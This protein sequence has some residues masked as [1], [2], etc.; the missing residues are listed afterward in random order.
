MGE[1]GWWWFVR[2]LMLLQLVN[3]VLSWG[4]DGHFA[5][6]KIAEVRDFTC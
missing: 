4:K 2:A 5:T 3:G 1:S 6:C